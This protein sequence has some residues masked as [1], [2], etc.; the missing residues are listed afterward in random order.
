MSKTKEKR[1]QKQRGREEKML[2]K[3]R[4][5]K[6]IRVVYEGRKKK[7]A[8]PNRLNML[9]SIEDEQTGQ[10]TMI[11]NATKVYRKLLPGLVKKFAEIKDPRRPGNIKHK[12]TVL[13]LYGILMFVYQVGP[14]REANRSMTRIQFEN[15]QAIFP[16]LETMP[17]AD[18]LARLLEVIE[19]GQ[20]QDCMVGLLNDLIRSKKFRNYLVRKNYLIAIDGTQ[21]LFR[22]YKWED[23]CLKR[24]VGGEEKV[25]QYYVYILE[26]VLVLDN[27]ITLPFL[28]EF[29]KDE[30]YIEGVSK[31]DCERKAFVRLAKRIK[32]KFPRLKITLL[33]D[34]LYACGPVIRKCKE[35]GWGYMIT[36]KEGAMPDVWHEAIGLMKWAPENSLIVKWGERE[37]LYTWANGIEYHYG[38]NGRNKEI[39]HVVN[40]YESWEEN[41][42]RS[43]GEVGR[44]Q[45][46]YSWIS[47]KEI[48]KGNVFGRCTRMGRYR[49]CIE[50]NI[51]TEKH[52]GYE[53]QHC[54]S[55]NWNAM[56]GYHY[57][58][59]IGRLVNVLA[60]NSELLTQMVKSLGIRGF[61]AEF[62]RTIS[63]TLID[64]DKL[65]KVIQERYQLKLVA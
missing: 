5:G 12:H 61:I 1:A 33:V 43:T 17:H 25:P 16:E 37:Q 34:G 9:D 28:S 18:T 35:F 51:L 50:N 20:I 53:Y 10:Q 30:E 31:Q 57:L 7:Q 40:C 27:G 23:N 32:E 42:S 6:S 60:A 4:E 26:S 41:H 14:R 24:N 48:N 44:K 54:Y 19:V 49:W 39:V 21:K 38:E 58:M 63:C 65:S 22:D 2:K 45:T 64:K 11:E 52:Q 46:R 59:K 3:V 62:R 55:Y 15:L 47:S 36:L 56:E 8:L 13:L 29:L